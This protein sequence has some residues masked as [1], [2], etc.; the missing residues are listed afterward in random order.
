MQGGYILDAALEAGL[1]LPF[2]C[3]GGICGCCVGRVAD[4][5]ADQ[6]DVSG[7]GCRRALG[8]TAA[9]TAAVLPGLHCTPDAP[10][11]AALASLVH[12]SAALPNRPIPCRR[13]LTC[14]LY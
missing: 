3:K 10:A 9:A 2:T 6:S 1:E 4:G 5:Q 14:R 8:K 13:L 12:V 11:A 7:H